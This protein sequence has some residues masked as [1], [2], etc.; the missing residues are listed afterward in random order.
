[1]PLSTLR[2][3]IQEGKKVRR[4]IASGNCWKIAHAETITSRGKS[5]RLAY[6]DPESVLAGLVQDNA[7]Q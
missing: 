2:F 6:I 1:M 7:A 3:M 4:E 5:L